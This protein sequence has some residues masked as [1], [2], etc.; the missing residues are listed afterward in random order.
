LNNNI[1]D[2]RSERREAHKDFVDDAAAE[3]LKLRVNIV[4]ELNCWFPKF[5]KLRLDEVVKDV[6]GRESRDT[7]TFVH[8]NRAF[9]DH[10]R[11]FL[12]RIEL[13]VL[14]VELVE[15]HFDSRT[16]RKLLLD[17]T[18]TGGVLSSCVVLAL[19]LILVGLNEFGDHVPKKMH[20]ICLTRRH[21]NTK[22]FKFFFGLLKF[23]SNFSDDLGKIVLDVSKEN[24]GELASK[25][26]A[27]E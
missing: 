8:C 2:S 3:L 26:I 12:S 5:F 10:I 20:L 11:V 21:G 1:H 15:T 24:F 4:K 23:A 27:A 13:I 19:D 18:T 16:S 7:I 6:D 17:R 9:D 25:N 14:S 22:I